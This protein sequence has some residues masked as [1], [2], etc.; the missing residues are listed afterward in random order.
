LFAAPSSAASAVA[1]A[2]KS[3][4]F[5]DTVA[6]PIALFSLTSEPPASAMA[7]RAALLLAPSAYTTM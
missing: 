3:L 4:F 1:S 5:D 6:T 7:A 2:T